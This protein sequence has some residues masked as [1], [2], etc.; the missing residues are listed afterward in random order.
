MVADEEFN[1]IN[2]GRLQFLMA[3]PIAFVDSILEFKISCLLLSVYLQSTDFPDR[4]KTAVASSNSSHQSSSSRPFQ[5]VFLQFSLTF[6]LCLD[7][8]TTSQ[9]LFEK[10]L[11]TQF[12]IKPEPP[13]MTSFLNT[14]T[15]CGGYFYSFFSRLLRFAFSSKEH[16][17]VKE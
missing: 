2:G 13:A 7:K 3:S 12:P 15:K 5:Y 6:F 16:E 8:T 17:E 10:C 11:L 14:F 4:F 1:H 9:P